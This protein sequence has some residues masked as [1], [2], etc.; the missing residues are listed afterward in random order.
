MPVPSP[1]APKAARPLSKP[2][3]VT[4][5]PTVP[6][7]ALAAMPMTRLPWLRRTTLDAS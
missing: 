6:L 1:S 3:T 2:V 7:A 5:S 4:T